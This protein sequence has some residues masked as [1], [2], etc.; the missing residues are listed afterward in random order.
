MID[1]WNVEARFLFSCY[2]NGVIKKMSALWRGNTIS[3]GKT[4][5]D[6]R[7]TRKN[8]KDLRLYF[9][10]FSP[11][12]VG[13]SLRSPIFTLSFNKVELFCGSKRTLFVPFA[14]T[15][16]TLAQHWHCGV[17]KFWWKYNE[18]A[19][20]AILKSKWKFYKGSSVGFYSPSLWYFVFDKIE[21]ETLLREIA[22]KLKFHEV[23]KLEDLLVIMDIM[24]LSLW[25][26][27]F[28]WNMSFYIIIQTYDV[29][30]II[31][32]RNARIKFS[33]L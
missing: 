8:D 12:N 24:D 10:P 9:F 6:T 4:F 2:E 27:K 3:R 22:N 7:I 13:V 14:R 30:W 29:L 31:F 23:T 33:Q 21:R 25:R 1:F 26:V 15:M 17:I 28:L 32:M 19:D 11:P 20:N 16:V 5:S 18:T